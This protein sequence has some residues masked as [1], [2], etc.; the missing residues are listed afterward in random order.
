M[1]RKLRRDERGTAMVE[2]S[3]VFPI[4]FLTTLGIMEFGNLFAQWILAEKATEMGVR[5]AV[6]S[7]MAA[8]AVPDCG[9]N[10]SQPVGTPCRQVAGSSTWA[11]TCSAG[12]GG[13]DATAF[14]AIVAK[15]QSVYA[16]VAPAN[17]VVEYTGTGL[18]YVGR[19]MPVPDVTVRLQNMTFT[20]VALGGLV[21]TLFGGALGDTVQM[22]DFRAT[23][24]GEDLQS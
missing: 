14:N 3:I 18:G 21:R 19:G 5:F 8:T 7:N 24:T 16:R 17:V 11:R 23:L 12:A 20:F 6:T 9:V 4:I 13:C 22:P 15:M 2:M 1:K 10:T